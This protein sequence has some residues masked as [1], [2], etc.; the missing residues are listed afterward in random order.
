[1]AVGHYSRFD[2]VILQTNG[3]VPF[4]SSYNSSL[5][6]TITATHTSS[7]LVTFSSGLAA[8]S[9]NALTLTA[10]AVGLSIGG[11]TS[12]KTLTVTKTITLTAADDTST[13]NIG[14][15]GTLNSAAYSATSS[16]QAAL[17]G[18]G[19]V[20]ISGTTI[21]YDNS[22]YLTSYTETSTL[23][24][25]C[26]RGATTTTNITA[27]SFIKTSGTS[28]QF[29]KADGS[30]DSSVY[31][32]TLTD[33]LAT[34][35][36]R[37]ASTSTLSTFSGGLIAPTLDNAGSLT[38]GGVNATTL[39]LGTATTVQTVNIGTGS[40]VTTINLGGAGDT[41]NIAGTLTYVNT[42]DLTVTDKLI[43]LNKGGAA[44]SGGVAGISIEENAVITGYAET[45][46]DRTGWTF[47]APA[48][49]GTFTLDPS[50]AA[51]DITLQTAVL[52]ANRTLT[53]R[54][55]TG[56]VALTSDTISGVALGNNLS[57]LTFATSGGAA[58]GST[59]NGS[60]AVT[61]SPASI[62]AQPQL[63]GTGFVK[64]SG[65]TI[66]YDPNTYLTAEVDTLATVTGRGATT[67]SP[68]TS[69]T[70]NLTHGA[71]TSATLTTSATTASQVLDSVA[72]GTARTLKYLISVT[73]G[74]SYQCSEALIIHD[75]TNTY[76]TE[77]AILLPTGSQIATFDSTISGGNVQLLVTPVNAI[78]TI[79][80]IRTIV[81][82]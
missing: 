31:L 42:T 10:N 71:I 79:K 15:G 58:S 41:V 22:T 35:T 16:F 59:Y 45:I 54:D 51:F 34:V 40:G 7:N 25:V 77:Y 75:G 17:S 78:T 27:A 26:T 49:S 53:L 20:K 43:V 47:K 37:G 44:A 13:L 32:T 12:A 23:Q 57:S 70:Y 69:P 30:S 2:P 4:L 36:G 76:M 3:T 38:I 1:M 28:S 19:F 73:A 48:S 63:T 6:Q 82:V 74:S 52:T 80:V 24:N 21:S 68:I 39:N 11:G 5:S 61:I 18:T 29:L 72:I 56:T 46:S 67:T 81:N 65:T 60:G 50:T 55:A 64:A 9:F 14:T 62:G 66:S 8:T 33:T